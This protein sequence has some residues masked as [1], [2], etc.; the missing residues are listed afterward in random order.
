[1][2]KEKKVYTSLFD[3]VSEIEQDK[4]S[5]KTDSKKMD[6]KGKEASAAPQSE[7]A[8]SD[9]EMKES[10]D[11]YKKLHELMHDKVEQMLG[12]KQITRRMLHD[13]F[14]VSHNFT[15]EQWQLIQDQKQEVE[16][17]LQ[18]LLPH[19][20][21]SSETKDPNIQDPAPPKA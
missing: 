14:S 5:K 11:Q 19:R 20:E 2:S 15:A 16:K 4:T 3:A 8:K 6:E 17:R 13:F 21:P 9:Q 12:Q 18:D 1:M 7:G 10:F